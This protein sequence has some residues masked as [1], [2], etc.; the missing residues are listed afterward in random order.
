MFLSPK[1]QGPALLRHTPHHVADTSELICVK[2]RG[3]IETHTDPSPRAR[4]NWRWAP[5]TRDQRYQFIRQVNGQAHTHTRGII[6]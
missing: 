4:R 5:G 2:L 1:V 3:S 6:S